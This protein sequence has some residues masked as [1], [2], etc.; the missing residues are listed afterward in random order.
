MPRSGRREGELEIASLV[1]EL[2]Y[3]LGLALDLGDEMADFGLGGREFCL[4]LSEDLLGVVVA[5]LKLN[6]FVLETLSLA[7][8]CLERCIRRVELES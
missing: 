1:L 4:S 7:L 6:D 2:Y 8:G 5:G 3:R